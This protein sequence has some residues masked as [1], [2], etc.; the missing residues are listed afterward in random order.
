[1]ENFDDDN[2]VLAIQIKGHKCYEGIAMQ[3]KFF[4]QFMGFPTSGRVTFYS[5]SFNCMKVDQ[6]NGFV[7]HC[8]LEEI[9]HMKDL[10]RTQ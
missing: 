1:M 10:K 9:N 6:E 8:L 2:N 5:K 3:K 4:A 7:P